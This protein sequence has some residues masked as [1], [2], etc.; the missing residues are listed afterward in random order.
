MVVFDGYDDDEPSTKDQ[1][2]NQ[3]NSLLKPADLEVE[4]DMT[5]STTQS[6]NMER[7]I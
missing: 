6:R 3:S 2:H 5:I 7:L 4:F 1:K